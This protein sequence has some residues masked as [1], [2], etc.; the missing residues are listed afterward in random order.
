MP[1]SLARIRELRAD[2]LAEDL[3]CTEDMCRKACGVED[4][5]TDAVVR[6]AQAC[7]QTGEGVLIINRSNPCRDATT[8]GR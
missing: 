2:C 5:E 3:P 7:E 4:Q 1:V 8:G 6:N